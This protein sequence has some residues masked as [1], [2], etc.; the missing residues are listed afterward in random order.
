MLNNITLR[1]IKYTD[2]EFFNIANSFDPKLKDLFIQDVYKK[3]LI[4]IYNMSHINSCQFL[5]Y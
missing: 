5:N 3:K 2:N 1:F 4:D